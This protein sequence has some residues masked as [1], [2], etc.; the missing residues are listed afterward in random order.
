[1]YYALTER[2]G[3]KYRTPLK[4]RL[5]FSEGRTKLGVQFVKDLDYAIKEEQAGRAIIV[6]LD[7]SYCH[8]NH[9]PKKCWCGDNVGRVERSRSKGQLTIILHAL[10]KDGWLIKYDADGNRP[11]PE[12]FA[13]GRCLTSEMVWRGKIGR[14]DYHDNMDGVMFERRL[15]ERLIPTLKQGTPAK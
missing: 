14:G 1:M 13:S 6:Y 7:E 12:E 15:V 4:S 2:L 11:Q 3:L 5:I 8:T 10:T 9:M